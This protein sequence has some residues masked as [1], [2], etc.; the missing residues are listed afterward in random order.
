MAISDDAAA[1]AASNLVTAHVA[2]AV[3]GN[4]RVPGYDKIREDLRDLFDAYLD[5]I[6]DITTGH[7][8]APVV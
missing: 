5:D 6:R 8:G 4:G 1:I 7:R 3:A 2:L